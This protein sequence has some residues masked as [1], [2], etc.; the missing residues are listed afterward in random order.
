MTEILQQVRF[1]I[2]SFNRRFSNYLQILGH[3][4][5]LLLFKKN[6]NVICKKLFIVNIN[7]EVSILQ[8]ALSFYMKYIKLEINQSFKGNY[9]C[10]L[11]A[12]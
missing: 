12:N 3:N 2:K 6:P 5:S 7:L 8:W 1:L 4:R 11:Y 10:Y 9:Q